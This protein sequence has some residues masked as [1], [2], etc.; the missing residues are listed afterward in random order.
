MPEKG[1]WMSCKPDNLHIDNGSILYW[2]ICSCSDLMM[3][4][5]Y[6]VSQLLLVQIKLQKHTSSVS[7]GAYAIFFKD[8]VKYSVLDSK[9]LH[10]FFK[11]VVDYIGY[12]VW[13]LNCM[14]YFNS[15]FSIFG[16]VF[17]VSVLNLPRSFYFVLNICN[18]VLCH[19]F[20]L[21]PST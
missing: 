5:I 17:P 11:I 15:R 9:F 14:L 1:K 19:I 6:S 2:I 21:V 3:A 16:I 13:T 20:C 18:I 7:R 12:V 8:K 10:Y 4:K